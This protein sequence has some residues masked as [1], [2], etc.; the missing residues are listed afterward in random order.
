MINATRLVA[1]PNSGRS[2]FPGGR[3]DGHLC[4]SCSAFGFVISVTHAIRVGRTA[5]ASVMA[6]ALQARTEGPRTDLANLSETKPGMDSKD[7]L[8]VSTSHAQQPARLAAS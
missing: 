5:G 8:I 4:G 1:G 7:R 6:T 3:T 2:V